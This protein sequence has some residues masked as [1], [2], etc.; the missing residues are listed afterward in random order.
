M[1]YNKI[2]LAF[3]QIY[4]FKGGTENIPLGLKD[5]HCSMRTY[6]SSY[7][8]ALLRKS[9]IFLTEYFLL[10]HVMCRGFLY[11]SCLPSYPTNKNHTA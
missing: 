1:G 7:I 6:S 2:K 5:M 10:V 4:Q 9:W 11:A 3:K 8:T